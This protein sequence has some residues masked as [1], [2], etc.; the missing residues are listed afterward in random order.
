MYGERVPDRASGQSAPTADLP[1]VLIE[2]EEARDLCSLGQ[3]PG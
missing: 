2:E 1:S 3:P